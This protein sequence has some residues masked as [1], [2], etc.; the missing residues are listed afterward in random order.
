MLSPYL[1]LRVKAVV[2]RSSRRCASW[3]L[4]LPFGAPYDESAPRRRRCVSAMRWQPRS[5]LRR[6]CSACCLASQT[7]LRAGRPGTRHAQ[8]PQHL[9]SSARS[10]C[11]P[12]ASVL[13]LCYVMLCHGM[14]CHLPPCF[15]ARLPPSLRP[16]SPLF[17]RFYPTFLVCPL[18][19]S[20]KERRPSPPWPPWKTYP[21]AVV[22]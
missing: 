19:R 11:L 6:S 7:R 14:V 15:C 12:P 4:V 20:I 3:P 17:V 8:P 9:Q 16:S 21:H 1:I 5:R 2:Q 13:L 10:P 18:T 22:K